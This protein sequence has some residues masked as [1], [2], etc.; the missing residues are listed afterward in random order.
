[1]GEIYSF[2]ASQLVLRYATKCG[3]ITQR[4]TDIFFVKI[5]K[6]GDIGL[7]A[8]HW[9]KCGHLRILVL[10]IGVSKQMTE[11]TLTYLYEP[12]HRMNIRICG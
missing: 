2:F 8:H 1:M 3:A 11:R 9:R 4:S 5:Y 7:L 6:V 12:L 10:F